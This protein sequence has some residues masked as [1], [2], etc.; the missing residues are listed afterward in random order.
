MEE[1][2]SEF[3]ENIKSNSKK[4]FN[5]LIF[6]YNKLFQRKYRHVFYSKQFRELFELEKLLEGTFKDITMTKENF[7]SL[8]HSPLKKLSFSNE[9]YSLKLQNNSFGLNKKNPKIEN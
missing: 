3:L 6:L 2:D 5:E 9:N 7:I 1:M 4:N 8:N